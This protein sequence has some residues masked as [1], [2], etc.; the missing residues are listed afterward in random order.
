[1]SVI[2]S[3]K[4]QYTIPGGHAEFL[5]V[6]IPLIVSTGIEALQ[7]FLNR[8]F[9]SRYSQ[10][11]FIASTPA[12]LINWS[13]VCF[14]FGTLTY[15]DIFI[16]QYYGQKRYKEIG[17]V[18]WQGIYLALFAACIVCSIS[19]F[20]KSFFMNVGHPYDVACEEVKYFK[21]LCYGSL[22]CLAETVFAGFYAGLGKTKVVL[23]V[24]LCGVIANIIL[25]FCLIYGNFGLPNLGI[26]GAALANNISLFIVCVIYITLIVSKKNNSIYNTRNIKPNFTFIKKLLF[27]GVPNGGEFFF[28]TIGFGIF[29]IIIG[30]LGIYE[31]V[32]SNIVAT[33]NHILSVVIVGCGMA[34]SLMVGKYLGENKIHIA[35]TSVKSAIHIV[36]TYVIIICFCL[37][38][39]PNKFIMLFASNEQIVLLY[40]IRP[41]LVNLL[42]MLS[43]Y[44]IF[45]ASNIIF[46]AAI[47]G[48]GDTVYVVKKFILFSIFLIIVPTYVSVIFFKLGIYIAWSFILIY[49]MALSLSFYYGYKSKK[50]ITMRI[51]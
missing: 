51:T 22:P 33:I 20:A 42:R 2:D 36:Y 45:N 18:I 48:A 44:L 29:I 23:M 9:L 35:K 15:I 49:T 1:M 50:W 38:F 30:H 4:E 11:S 34:T 8:I 43:F 39:C 26:T 17:P 27:Y 28:D 37:I 5:K 10:E 14:F 21:T 19:M 3:L 46:A 16:A 41:M 24:S 13:M 7:L 32:A 47:K 40:K 12:G 6:S 25:D 31:L